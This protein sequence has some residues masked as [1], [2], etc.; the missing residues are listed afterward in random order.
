MDKKKENYK[1]RISQELSIGESNNIGQKNIK[2][3]DTNFELKTIFAASLKPKPLK[4][5][6]L[7]KNT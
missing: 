4:Y 7:N 1:N 6:R 5:L 2:I 3:E